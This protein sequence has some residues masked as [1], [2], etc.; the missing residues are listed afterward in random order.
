[1]A[2]L[3]SA[4]LKPADRYLA[5][6]SGMRG[7][8]R[9]YCLCVVGFWLCLGV[10]AVRAQDAIAPDQSLIVNSRVTPANDPAIFYVDDGTVSG[11]NLIHSFESFSIPQGETVVFRPDASISDVLSRV[12]GDQASSLDGRLEVT[13][14]ANFF[15]INPNGIIFGANSSLDV[16]GSLVAA[17]A[18]QFLFEDGF[19]L[20][21]ETS[22]ILPLLSLS[23]PSGLQFGSA[24]GAIVHRS[25]GLDAQ[26]NRQ[27]LQVQSGKTLALLGGPVEIEGGHIVSP[28]SSIELGGIGANSLVKLRFSESQIIPGYEEA[29]SFSDI[30]LSKLALIDSSGSSGGRINL[31]GQNISIAD[32]SQIFSNTSGSGLGKDIL[33]RA[34]RNFEIVGV[35]KGVLSQDALAFGALTAQESIVSAQLLGDGQGGNLFI[36]AQ[37]ASIRDGAALNTSSRGSGTGGD[38]NFDVEQSIEISGKAELL[39]T[40]TE[41]REFAKAAELDPKFLGEI[42]TAS[43]VA[44]LNFSTGQ[45]GSL[46]LTSNSLVLRDGGLINAN[47]VSTG[48][49]G[50]INITVTESLEL[51]GTADSEIYATSITA[52]P[53]PHPIT[54]QGKP[55]NLN[56]D[57]SQIRILD[58]ARI[59]LDTARTSGGLARIKTSDSIEI[60]GRSPSG[61]LPSTISARSTVEGS[62]GRIEIETNRLSLSNYGV[63]FSGGSNTFDPGRPGFFDP[64]NQPKGGDI[65]VLANSISLAQSSQI[66]TA[67]ESDLGGNIDLEIKDTLLL[68]GKSDISAQAGAAGDG[69][70]IAIKA[71]FLVTVPSEN[72]DIVASAFA[73]RGGNVDITAQ[74]ILGF[75]TS[76]QATLL[77]DISAGSEIGIDGN[78][79]IKSPDAE[80]D[81]TQA[82]LDETFAP[83][84]LAANCYAVQAAAGG[85]I[86]TGRGG[87][88]SRPTGS[89]AANMLWQDFGPLPDFLGRSKT[90]FTSASPSSPSLQPAKLGLKE[91]IDWTL[92]EDGK[93]QLV[94]SEDGLLDLPTASVCSS[95]S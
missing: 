95:L 75:N 61:A 2:L 57:A 15:L 37:R 26:G 72:S 32:G 25:R 69:G 3:L 6:G 82:R 74:G 87:L 17:T 90:A 27:G 42:T 10:G 88:P 80:L 66:S 18:A 45:S 49:G 38:L 40:T 41:L 67:A 51:W 30:K 91:A 28:Q 79:T 1:M 56:I 35:A 5:Q 19:V 13:G 7:F 73:G 85:F 86:R 22:D 60:S 62:G 55:G 48:P 83:P 77:S 53:I 89:V 81:S 68:R 76:R 12:T 71:K 21:A 23:R 46:N 33:I 58:G 31:R 52:S 11:T 39:G 59:G 24:P 14:N 34:S 63:I 9:E 92:T 65:K 20:G 4:G 43:S 93:V 78:V 70:N 16:G 47:P 84:P 50:D 94:S 29:A 54:P 8:R 64:D 44:V 36:R